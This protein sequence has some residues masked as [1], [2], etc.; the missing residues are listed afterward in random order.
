MKSS[1]DTQEKTQQT[2]KACSKTCSQCSGQC[3]MNTNHAGQHKCSGG[4][5]WS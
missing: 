1:T 4:H 3:S 5:N 2:Q